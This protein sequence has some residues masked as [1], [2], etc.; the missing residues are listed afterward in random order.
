[1]L[2]E[3]QQRTSEL[4]V[5]N[6]LGTALARQLDAGAIIRLEGEQA[7]DIFGAEVVNILLHNAATGM[8]Y[9]AYSYDRGDM[10]TAAPFPLGKGLTSAV[11]RS[12]QPLLLGTNEEQVEHGALPWY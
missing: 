1:M 9:D 3:T 2:A 12:R 5:I 7:Q 6:R 8:I 10:T 4:E 11:I